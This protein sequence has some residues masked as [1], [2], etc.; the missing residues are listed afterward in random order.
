MS[1]E[2]GLSAIDAI[3]E[4]LNRFENLSNVL[5]WISGHTHY[6]YDFI[7]PEGIRLISNQ[8]GYR[9]EAVSKDTNFNQDGLYEINVS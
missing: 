2:K 3:Y 8:L 4:I 7:T 6:S 9:N 5:C 1:D